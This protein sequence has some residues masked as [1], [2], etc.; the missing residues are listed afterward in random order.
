[1]E[2][3]WFVYQ[4]DHHKGPFNT[5][6]INR[7]F[8]AGDLLEVDFV[9]KE[10]LSD[11][12][13]I[14]DVK[15]RVLNIPREKVIQ[16]TRMFEDDEELPP[17]L[18]DLPD[19]AYE[20]SFLPPIPDEEIDKPNV[21]SGLSERV[22][23][24][25]RKV[26]KPFNKVIQEDEPEKREFKLLPFLFMGLVLIFLSTFLFVKEE[27]SAPVSISASTKLKLEKIIKYPISSGV[28]I[29]VL[30]FENSKG[31]WVA[32]NFDGVLDL[33]FT[34]SSLPHKILSKNRIKV[35]G[36]LNTENNWGKLNEWTY[37]R[38]VKLY[39]GYYELSLHGVKRGWMNRVYIELKNL[40]LF[41]QIPFIKDY[42]S[43]VT[44][45][46][47][48]LMSGL[49]HSQFNKKLNEFWNVINRAKSFSIEK[50][51]ESYRTFDSLLDQIYYIYKSTVSRIVSTKEMD[52]FELKYAKTIGPMMRALI[53][54]NY[55]LY[56][57]LKFK[58]PNDAKEYFHLFEY[59]KDIGEMVSNMLT[60]TKKIKILNPE[61]KLILLN[62]YKSEINSL[63]LKGDYYLK[64]L[65]KALLQN[66]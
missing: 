53:L 36:F 45:K 35:H 20:E 13:L 29:R 41:K 40:P 7:M 10:G 44:Y 32:T 31:L 42:Q 14:R 18:P 61:T 2:K 22:E 55:H 19:E 49:V 34:L 39:P 38:G 63:K 56:E 16:I 28:K 50:K 5:E 12:T 23:L 11:W 57:K 15:P 48:I 27:K 3:E 62:K 54:E 24:E 60:H 21:V 4:K 6:D 8:S 58:K 33:T 17:D 37:D 26:E 9:W 65:E 47:K 52:K 59:G 46:D 25:E 66:N 43:E 51:V 1:M 64:N 30:P